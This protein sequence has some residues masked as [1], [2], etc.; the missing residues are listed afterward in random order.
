MEAEAEPVLD[1]DQRIAA[2]RKRIE[3]RNV[4]TS[5]EGARAVKTAYRLP[6]PGRP[7]CSG[8]CRWLSP[9]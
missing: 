5:D 8:T 6:S 1:R 4:K 3:E 9:I 7:L 2:R